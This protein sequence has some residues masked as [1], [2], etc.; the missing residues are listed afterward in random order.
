MLNPGA[1]SGEQL[2][3]ASARKHRS[4]YKS[5]LLHALLAAK[6]TLAHATSY[7][8]SDQKDERP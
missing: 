2:A 1:A 3:M 6:Q 4:E 5:T 7:E 8:T